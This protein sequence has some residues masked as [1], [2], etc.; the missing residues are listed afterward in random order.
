MG[1]V[2]QARTDVTTRSTRAVLDRLHALVCATSLRRRS[3]STDVRNSTGGKLLSGVTLAAKGAIDGDAD[4]MME[5]AAQIN[6]ATDSS[7]LQSAV[8][9]FLRE[10]PG[11]A[12]KVEGALTSEAMG[13]LLRERGVALVE[14]ADSRRTQLEAAEADAR[15]YR[16]Q[17][18][19]EAEKCAR[20]QAE[21]RA[22]QEQLAQVGRDWAADKAK[23]GDANPLGEAAAAVA[24]VGAK[25]EVQAGEA[26]VAAAEE[27]MVEVALTA[28]DLPAVPAAAAPAAAAG[29]AETAPPP[30]EQASAVC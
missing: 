17:A 3:V 2:V 28:E 16:L 5:G 29:Q 18:T 12:A 22:L 8:T 21:V 23:A 26:A 25:E 1:P 27:E 14:A 20:L 24:A 19:A 15:K 6:F 10:T 13:K 11:G 30:G 7:V 4:T 9:D